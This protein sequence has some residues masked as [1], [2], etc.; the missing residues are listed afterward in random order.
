MGFR[1]EGRT[2]AFGAPSRSELKDQNQR[3]REKRERAV[4]RYALA[5]TVGRLEGSLREKRDFIRKLM[6]VGRLPAG[7]VPSRETI[8][9]LEARWRAGE[10]EIEDYLDAYRG[11]RPA[12]V[13]ATVLENEIHRVIQGGYSINAHALTR[14]LKKLAERN[15]VEAPS[16]RQVHRRFA[17]AGR[18]VRAGS[19]YGSRAGEIDGLP[20]A[21]IVSRTPHQ[22]WALDELTLPIWVRI[23]DRIRHR[24]VSARCDVVL[25]IDVC[26]GAVVGYWICD[27]SIRLDETGAPMRAGFDSDDVVAALLSAAVPELAPDGTRAFAGYLPD[28][29]RLDNVQVH[30]AV[31]QWA[32]NAGVVI[33]W[34][35]IRVRRAASNAAVERRVAIMKTYCAD[36]L[37]HVD[38]HLPTDQVDS[39]SD[40][41]FALERTK[42]AGYTSERLPR[43]LPILPDD[44]HSVAEIRIIFD[45]V[46]RRYNHEF[47][48]RVHGMTPFDKYQRDW[49]RRP[50]R[51]LDLVRAVEPCTVRVTTDG[52]VHT[53][54]RITQ[55][56]YPILEGVLLMLDTAVTYHPDPMGRGIFVDYEGRLVHLRPQTTLTDEEAAVVARNQTAAARLI[57]D[58]AAR[59]REED[60]I[61]SVGLDGLEA[62]LQEHERRAAEVRERQKAQL[63]PG[64]GESPAP[65]A[66]TERPVI[67]PWA[68]A[69]PTAFIRPAEDDNDEE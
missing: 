36:I 11:G 45:D 12:E 23:Y 52:I 30:K 68:A 58:G 25:I 5:E 6:E 66:P 51:G 14:T 13:L 28:R 61:R 53:R 20:H 33:D 18:L 35:R 65:A 24:W 27:P 21:R 29:I 38:L 3:A 43:L 7:P 44:L 62:A 56:F 8:R 59:I 69:D 55:C 2:R 57:S 9:A 60:M 22:T 15:G 16:Y 1:T 26:S 63:L 42:A 19:R 54:N 46:V 48:N 67:N 37:G 64:S 49:V 31:Q 39:P 32:E 41:D 40:A 17:K 10:Q 50:R 34:Q 4:F 47:V